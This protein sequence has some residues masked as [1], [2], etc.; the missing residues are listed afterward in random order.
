MVGEEKDFYTEEAAAA[1][2]ESMTPDQ[3]AEATADQP[4]VEETSPPA[5]EP[6]A[7]AMGS[8]E[9]DLHP[10]VAPAGGAS[11]EAPGMADAWKEVGNQFAALGAGLAAAFRTGWRNE[12][13]R[14][15][16]KEMKGGLESLVNELG[17]AI[18]EGTVTPE[19]QKVKDEAGRAVGTFRS[20]GE[21]TVQEIRP[22]IAAALSDL[23]EEVRKL[24][25]R[26]KKEGEA[27]SASASEE[28]PAVP[29]NPEDPAA[30]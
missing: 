3:A 20:A 15:H 21:K 4:T 11:D 16:L 26:V 17:A 1:L 13:S 10:V 6:C 12:E 14:R 9:I 7:P 25:G 30:S 28:Q 8:E 22:K 2:S 24:A 23:N 5:E 29:G 19:A 27:D 18:R